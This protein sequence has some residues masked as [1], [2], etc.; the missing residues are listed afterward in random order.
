MLLSRRPVLAALAVVAALALLVPASGSFAVVLVTRILIFAILAM[1]V[2]LL[3]GYTGLSSLGQAAYFGVGAYMAAILAERFQIGLGLDF[4]GILALGMLAGGILA[5]IFGLLA[6]RASGVSFLMITLALGQCAWG[7]A[8]R[9]NSLTG[10]DNG[11]TL[12]TRPNL[13]GLDLTDKVVF[14]WVVLVVFSA[15]AIAM[16]TLVRSPFGLGLTGIREREVRMQ[17][18]GYNTW[19]YKYMLFVISGA[20]AGLAGVLW[21]HANGHV[22][23]ELLMLNTSIDALLVVVL[24][25]AGTL[26]GS[27]LGTAI[28]FGLRE[29]LSTFVPW[30]QYVLGIVYIVAI[31]YLPNGLLGLRAR[32]QQR[33]Q[34]HKH[35]VLIVPKN[36]S[37]DE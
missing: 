33:S 17:A 35:P 6:L 32:I 18:L 7:L 28:V 15:A 8:Y 30:W 31:L 24:G 37:K 1:S 16:R 5:A 36:A 27:V 21:A 4:I 34:R 14:F 10:G 23:P 13:M 19:L 3:L 22:S 29:Y 12:R 26:F 2:D 11:V 20:F 25:G 9:W